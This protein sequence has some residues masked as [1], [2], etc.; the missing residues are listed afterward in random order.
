MKPVKVIN[1]HGH[2]DH[3]EANGHMKSQYNIPVLMHPVESKAFGILLDEPLEEN[4]IIEFAG[5]NIKVLLTPGHTM[6]SICLLADNFML[7]GDTLFAGSMG[8]TDLGG[9][10]KTMMKTLV[11]LAETVPDETVLYPGHGPRTTMGKEKRTNP[12]LLQAMNT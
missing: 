1:T 7:T 2:I 6:G 9:D 3:I 10:E 12:F 8:R 5:E 4:D 11:R